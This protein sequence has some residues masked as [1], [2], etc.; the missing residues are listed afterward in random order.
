VTDGAPVPAAAALVDE[1]AAEDVLWELVVLDVDPLPPHAASESESAAVTSTNAGTLGKATAL[2]LPSW[3]IA[4]L[5]VAER[6]QAS[7]GRRLQ[8]APLHA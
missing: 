2:C 4:A 5:T 1:L 6:L 8:C 3:G 7:A